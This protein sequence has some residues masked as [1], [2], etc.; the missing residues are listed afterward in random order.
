MRQITIAIL[1]L[2]ARQTLACDC[3]VVPLSDQYVDSEAVFVGKVINQVD[4][5]ELEHPKPQEQSKLKR[6]YICVGGPSVLLVEPTEAFKNQWHRLQ[7]NA[8]KFRTVWVLQDGSD[9]AAYMEVGKSYLIFGK[10][11][12][13][14]MYS[15]S[16][17]QGTTDAAGAKEIIQKLRKLKT[18]FEDASRP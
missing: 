12:N 5:C 18:A 8:A 7:D 10:A 13:W 2:L 14:D 1:L 3:V 9:C 17:C 15:T 6:E 11:V 16:S 4:L